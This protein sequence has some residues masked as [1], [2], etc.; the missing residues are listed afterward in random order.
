MLNLSTIRDK[1]DLALQAVQEDVATIRTGRATPSLIENVVIPAY[2]GTQNLKVMELGTI[3]APEPH[4]LTI[5]PWDTSVVGEIA[6][7]I[8][9]AN[10]GIQAVVDA[11]LV[12]VNIPPL[13]QERR[14]E[15]VKLLKTKTE[16]GKV[17][18]RQIRHEQMIHLKKAF[19]AKEVNEDDKFNQE[20]ELQKLT[21][22]FVGK[23]DDLF[24]AKEQELLTV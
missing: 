17:M 18:L 8:N 13:T 24:K 6:K 22:E 14:Q 7:G 19:E 23:I 9:Q 10:L 3:S 11:D 1:M 16:G 5:K 20:E 4:M 2:G 12:R 15:F 21:D